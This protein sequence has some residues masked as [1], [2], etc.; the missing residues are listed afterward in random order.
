MRSGQPSAFE[1]APGELLAVDV[2]AGPA[3]VPLLHRLWSERRGLHAARR[4]AGRARA[5][6]VAR[7]RPARPRC[8]AP[9]GTT[10]FAGAAPGRRGGRASSWRPRAPAARRDSWSSPAPRRCRPRSPGRATALARAG[11]A[12]DAPLVSCLTP[13]HIGGLLVLLRGELADPPSRVTVHE[14]FDVDRLAREAPAG[15]VALT[16]ARDGAPAR[17][18]RGRPG[19]VRSDAR[20][21]RRPRAR[22]SQRRPRRSGATHRGDLRAHRVVRRRGVRRRAVRGHAGAAGRR[23]AHR[24]ARSDRDAGV[25]PRRRRHRRRLRRARL[26]AHGRCRHD[27]RCRAPARHRP[28]R[29]GH[30]HRGGDGVAARG[31]AGDR[32]APEGVRGGRRRAGRIRSGASRSSPTSCLARSTTLPRSRSCAIT[33][34]RRSPATRHPASWC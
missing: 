19:A 34:A 7:P 22:R 18:R 24:A 21:R 16:R 28:A 30:P 33:R 32:V 4:A 31:R 20:R 6:A 11:H 8:S 10:V 14:R 13:A 2:P 17:A 12:V 29:R 1:V 3:W 25:P 15:R 5:A 27:R 26:V 23:A 9:G